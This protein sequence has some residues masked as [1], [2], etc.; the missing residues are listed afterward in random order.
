VNKTGEEMAIIVMVYPVEDLDPNPIDV[1]EEWGGLAPGAELVKL[2]LEG[3]KIA[4][5]IANDRV[6]GAVVKG[7][8]V[9]ILSGDYPVEKE[10]VYRE[11]IETIFETLDWEETEEVGFFNV[12]LVGKRLEGQLIT[13]STVEGYVPIVSFSQWD[14]EGAAGQEISITIDAQSRGDTQVDDGVKAVLVI[15]V[16][17]GEGSSLLASG[18]TSFTKRYEIIDLNLPA[19]GTYTI[20]VY[21]PVSGMPE[22]ELYQFFLFLCHS[23]R[24]GDTSEMPWYG[25]YQITL[26]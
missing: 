9:G 19:N 24:A 5:E 14:F 8:I 20:Q 23:S 4:Y 16:H 21:A 22:S 17:D 12:G 1:M 10:A 2:E 6:K 13:G 26:G 15:D 25:W 18:P 7:H 3:R 11:G